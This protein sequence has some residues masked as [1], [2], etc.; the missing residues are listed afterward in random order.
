MYHIISHTGL[1][2]K[3]F[4]LLNFTLNL[5]KILIDISH[6]YLQGLSLLVNGL[7]FL[8]HRHQIYIDFST[9]DQIH[10]EDI[11]ILQCSIAKLRH[12]CITSLALLLFEAP[13]LESA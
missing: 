2:S 3:Q 7:V 1:D 11:C 6:C 13:K 9:I 8:L 12:V 4:P 10:C 5:C